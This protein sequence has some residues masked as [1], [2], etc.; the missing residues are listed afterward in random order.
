MK[1]HTAT[2]TKFAAAFVFC[3]FSM[4][5]VQAQA[6]RIGHVS[7][8]RIMNES[9]PAKAANAKIEREF[10]GRN[11][12]LLSLNERLKSMASQLDKDMPVLADTE[13]VKRQR[14][15]A[16][17]DQEFQ[18]KQRAFREDL[19][20]RRN[21]EIAAVV[22]RANKA[23]KAIAESEKY[24]IILQDAIYYSPSIDIT[25]KVLKALAK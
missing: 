25:E 5:N 12:D 24:D 11:K 22:S 2:I 7:S 18:R 4:A 1:S 16:E 10:S 13:R 3:A 14:T 8:D 6:S 21:E 19:N 20:Q 9:A 23:I 17:L 15:L